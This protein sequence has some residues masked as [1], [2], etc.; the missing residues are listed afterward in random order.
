MGGVIRD[1]TIDAAAK[2]SELCLYCGLCCQGVL[3][4]NAGLAAEE[5][6]LATRLG[7]SL[8]TR[9]D[10]NTAFYLPCPC[11]QDNKCTV[12]SAGRPRVCA[13]Y[14][15]KL[16]MKYLQGEI[17]LEESKL[18]IDKAKHLAQAVQ[19][20]LAT[21]DSWQK[22]WR[23][24]VDSWDSEEGLCSVE[25]RRAHAEILMDVGILSV[26]LRR[27]FLKPARQEGTTAK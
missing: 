3:H 18:L 12:Y 11:H 1:E 24:I 4:S 7:L 10:G 20:R 8:Y 14:Q 21:D 23:Q 16:L 5:I 27:H 26:F 9:K 2:G 15:C 19:H 6:A 22:R 17:S 13:D 25:S